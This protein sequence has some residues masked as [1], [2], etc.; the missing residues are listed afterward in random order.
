MDGKTLAFL[1]KESAKAV[2]ECFQSGLT[3]DNLINCAVVQIQFYEAMQKSLFEAEPPASAPQC[4]ETC[5]ACCY[6]KVA[7]TIPE[8]FGIAAF[9][10]ERGR[11]ALDRAAEAA[12]RLHGETASLDDFGRV[13]TRLPCPLLVDQRCSVYELR[14]ISCRAVYS[15]DRS[16]C[17]NFYFNFAFDTR[18]PHYDLM[19]EAHGQM[20]L[21]YGRALEQLGLDGG[22]V[23]LGSAL[24]I[25]LR[26]TDTIDRYLAGER[27]FEAAKLGRFR[28]PG[29]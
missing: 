3:P 15:A 2:T 27:V 22:I 9:L 17:E 28:K 16:A 25:I 4:A 8:A 14:P 21:G 12:E 20:L 1:Q 10:G 7:C 13:K 18:I 5:T 24:A 26:Q 11:E 29:A 6:Q 23:E 19:I